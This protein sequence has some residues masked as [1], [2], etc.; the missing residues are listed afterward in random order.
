MKLKIKIKLNNQIL[1][2]HHLKAKLKY[3]LKKIINKL[4]I[5]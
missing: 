5:K 3:K 2:L 4:M 1:N